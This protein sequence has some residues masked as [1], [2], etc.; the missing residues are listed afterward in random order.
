MGLA[1]PHE[2][3]IEVKVAIMETQIKALTTDIDKMT[4]SIETLVEAMNRGKGAFGV[5]MTL[6]AGI[7]FAASLF[8]QWLKP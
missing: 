3:T 7:G 1:M 2:Q 6:A 8:V 5:A 4:R